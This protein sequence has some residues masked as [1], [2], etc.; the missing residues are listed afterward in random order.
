MGKKVPA[1][2]PD[3]AEVVAWLRSPEGEQ[4]SEQRMRHA[5]AVAGSMHMLARHEEDDGVFATVTCDGS[6]GSYADWPDPN[7]PADL[8]LIDEVARRE[9]ERAELFGGYVIYDEL[10]QFREGA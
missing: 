4:W 10:R 1:L 9:A 5:G 3:Q 8:D 6:V 7:P 2:D